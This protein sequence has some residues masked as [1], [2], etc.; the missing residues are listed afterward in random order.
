MNLLPSLSIMQQQL[1]RT[2]V[3]KGKRGSGNIEYNIETI[4]HF[5]LRINFTAHIHVARVLP[6]SH[7]N[8]ETEIRIYDGEYQFLVWLSG[9]MTREGQQEGRITIDYW[10]E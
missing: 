7:Q 4:L 8:T 5:C 10:P 3:L 6:E 1:K 2:H 9:K